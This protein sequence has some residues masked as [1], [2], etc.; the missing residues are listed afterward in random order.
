MGI[1]T[2]MAREATGLI[3]RRP[4]K[5]KHTVGLYLISLLDPEVSKV[6]RATYFFVRYMDDLLDGDRRLSNGYQVLP[7]IVDMRSQVETGRFTR[8]PKIMELAEYSLGA[9]QR[10]AL[11]GDDPRQD[12]LDEID[13]MVFDYHRQ[14]DRREL[15]AE[16]LTGYYRQTFHP[17]HNIMLVG[18][19]STLRAADIP[20]FSLCQG[21][22]YSVEHLQFDWRVGIINIPAEVLRTAGL[23][24]RSPYEAVRQSPVVNAWERN[25]LQESRTELLELQKMFR[26]STERV[27][28]RIYQGLIGSM[29]EVANRPFP[30]N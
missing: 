21:R 13:I 6:G 15:S 17:I 4:D 11:A 10:K 12:F 5:L 25:E 16:Q 7:H 1:E 24:S 22:V 19:G 9:L 29:L 23:T 3:M 20:T 28:P 8:E 14:Q 26:A 30:F 18:L 2:L 27:T